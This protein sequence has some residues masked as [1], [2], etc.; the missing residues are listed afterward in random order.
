MIETVNARIISTHLGFEDHG[1]FTCMIICEGDGWGQEF[2]GYRLDMRECDP[3]SN[4][5]IEFLKAVLKT[6]GCDSWEKLVN[7][8]VRLRRD[9]GKIYAIGHLI[10]EKWFNPA[11]LRALL[12]EKTE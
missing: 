5:G 4:Y 6:V 10:E 9:R 7:K 8:P 12:T 11:D 3:P 1:M 2:G